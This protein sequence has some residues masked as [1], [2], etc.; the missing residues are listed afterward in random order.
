[1]KIFVEDT[2][3]NVVIEENVTQVIEVSD[4]IFPEGINLSVVQ[5]EGDL[6]V[7]LATETVTRLPI[8]L[9]GEALIV[10][11]SQTG[12]LKW[13]TQSVAEQKIRFKLLDPNTY[14]GSVDTQIQVLRV[15]ADIT[16]TRIHIT[17]PDATPGAELDIDLKQADDTT[18]WTNAALLQACDTTNGVF[19]KTS[20]FTDATVAGGKYVYFEFGA[21]PHT[22]WKWIWAEIYY[23]YDS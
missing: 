2:A 12:K 7:G 17:G 18:S 19:T 5:A 8:G 13:G 3:E 22:D 23:N 6:L 4:A 21:Q 11:S 1:M 10:D 9:N 15:D 14:Y 20:G 16:L